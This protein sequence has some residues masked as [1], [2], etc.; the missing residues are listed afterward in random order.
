MAYSD[1]FDTVQKLYIAYYQRP[2]EPQGLIAWAKRLEDAGDDKEKFDKILAD[3][4]FS[5][6]SVALYGEI[7]KDNV[8]TVIRAVYDS[9]FGHGGDREGREYYYDRFLDGTYGVGDIV[10]TILDS[11]TDVGR[12]DKTTIDNK[13]KAA[14]I[15]TGV[16]AGK[17]V[18]DASFPTNVKDEAFAYKTGAVKES[19]DFLQ[20]VTDKENTILGKM[21]VE[22]M[23]IDSDEFEAAESYTPIPSEYSKVLTVGGTGDTFIGGN[24][25]EVVYAPASGLQSSL[26]PNDV[27]DGGGGRNTLKVDVPVFSGNVIPAGSSIK[28]FHVLDAN[29]S[30]LNNNTAVNFSTV[31]TA[32]EIEQINVSGNAGGVNVNAS[33]ALQGVHF[34]VNGTNSTLNGAGIKDVHIDNYGT[35]HTVSVKSNSKELNIK[36]DNVLNDTTYRIIGNNEVVTIEEQH[37]NTKSDTNVD[38][39]AS[40]KSL[41][42]K[43]NVNGLLGLS[44]TDNLTHLDVS[45]LTKGFTENSNVLASNEKVD[46]KLSGFGDIL[47]INSAIAAGSTI[48]LGGGNDRLVFGTGGSIDKDVVLIDGGAGRDSVDVRLVTNANGS[49]F[50][51]F[52]I[53]DFD[54]ATQTIDLSQATISGL[55]TISVGAGSATVHKAGASVENIIFNGGGTVALTNPGSNSWKVDVKGGSPNLDLGDAVK[56]VEI[57]DNS[58]IANTVAISH[59]D[60]LE[61]IVVKKGIDADITVTGTLG[62]SNSLKLAD[63]SATS[64][65]VTATLAT[66]PGAVIKG[67]SGND[68][69]T[70][71]NT[72]GE[73]SITGGGGDDEFHVSA[74]TVDNGGLTIIEDARAGDIIVG[75]SGVGNWQAGTATVLNAFD[76]IPAAIAAAGVAVNKAHQLILG[77]DSYIYFNDATTASYDA[78][79]VLVK[80]VG[81]NKD[82]SAD[83]V[84]I[85]GGSIT[86]S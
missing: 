86:L 83:G 10:W 61:E 52:E 45:E 31:D 51:N 79:D 16:V 3:F 39:N 11:A 82:L 50:K 81:Y 13:V 30:A 22:K 74:N 73:V 68:I 28:N 8:A 29:V 37:F 34:D 72:A 59:A 78:N 19:R 6:E 47:I 15:F 77:N 27:I 36:A 2:A 42:L 80:L 5:P 48:D 1:H 84:S 85:S 35:V 67:S 76:S 62:S 43:G 55:D 9:A 44:K 69:L 33:D 23:L 38:L 53:L 14:T 63:F 7:G 56:K 71:Q 20:K 58:A 54:S 18:K 46:V 40:V 64:S 41:T 60:G 57:T 66:A 17:D 4:A 12:K 70:I 75:L 32:K 65:G 24:G 49:K 21:A 25:D 26:D